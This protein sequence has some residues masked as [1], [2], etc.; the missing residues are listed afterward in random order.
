MPEPTSRRRMFET[1]SH[2]WRDAGLAGEL[3]SQVARRARIEGLALLA[4]FVAVVV[5]YHHRQDLLGID[6]AHSRRAHPEIDALVHVAI[7]VILLALGWA[8]ARDAGR[9]L[10]P[11]FFSRME[12]ATAGTAGFLIRLATV[13]VTLFIALQAAGVE[14][15]TL[16]LGG[17]VTAVVVGLAAQQT[18]GNLIAGMVLLS[19]RPFRVGDHVRL[20]GGPVGGQI[21]GIVSSLGLLYTTFATGGESVQ[22]PNGAVLSAAVSVQHSHA[23]DG[24]VTQVATGGER[25]DQDQE[26]ASEPART[27]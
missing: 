19:A 9:A 8:V 17:A 5:V 18:F 16:A 14:A 13:L 3:N 15:R 24:G 27:R 23:G 26:R 10:R 6:T 21:D 1:R 11:V 12:P 4:A 7:V 2:V 25:E 20:L 22:V